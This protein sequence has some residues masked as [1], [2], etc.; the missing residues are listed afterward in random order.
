MTDGQLDELRALVAEYPPLRHH[1][2]VHFLKCSF[3]TSPAQPSGWVREYVPRMIRTLL[4]ELRPVDA[5]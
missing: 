5:P 3:R 2:V 4:D 1:E